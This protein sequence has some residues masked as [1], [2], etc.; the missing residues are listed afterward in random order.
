MDLA[1]I[2]RLIQ[3]RKGRIDKRKDAGTLFEFEVEKERQKLGGDEDEVLSKAVKE[4]KEKLEQQAMS[5]P[6]MPCPYCGLAMTHVPE[7][8]AMVCQ[9]C[10][11]GVR[12]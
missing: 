5:A 3:D 7:Q 11:I 1:E 12:I 8:Q 10:G 6:Q 9:D 4:K 2:D